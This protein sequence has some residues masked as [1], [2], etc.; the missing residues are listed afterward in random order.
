MPLQS[1]PAVHHHSGSSDRHQ[2]AL[3]TERN[4]SQ[5]QVG[6]TSWKFFVRIGSHQ[7]AVVVLARFSIVLHSCTRT[8][9]SAV[10]GARYHKSSQAA[11]H[12][13]QLR[14]LSCLRWLI[15]LSSMMATSARAIEAFNITAHASSRCE[16][17]R[18]RE[19][20]QWLDQS[21]YY[22]YIGTR[23]ECI[24]SCHHCF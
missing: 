5:D 3:N 9:K 20:E 4:E 19:H 23:S 16:S 7:S 11:R 10:K 22:Q 21:C 14:L 24:P 8:R 1:P 2:Q 12:G 17:I 13:Q 6:V 18:R 15:W